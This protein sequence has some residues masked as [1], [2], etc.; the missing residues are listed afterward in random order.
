M[1]T[2]VVVGFWCSLPGVMAEDDDR[3]VALAGPEWTT[4]VYGAGDSDF[5]STL[6][7]RLDQGLDPVDSPETRRPHV[8]LL[9]KLRSLHNMQVLAIDITTPFQ[10]W[11]VI[12]KIQTILLWVY[13]LR[14]LRCSSPSMSEQEACAE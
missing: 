3:M 2:T 1:L 7:N 6:L 8:L 12:I 11:L 9:H 10:W 4:W 5:L 14:S 13:M